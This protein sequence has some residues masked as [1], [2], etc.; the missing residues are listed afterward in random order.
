MFEHYRKQKPS[1]LGRIVNFDE[2]L[3]TRILK[4]VYLA[5]AALIALGAVA[6][7]GLTSLL[8]LFTALSND[9]AEGAL[10]SL[11]FLGLSIGGG[12][13]GLLLWR[14]FCE[15]VIVVFKINENLQAV[16]DLGSAPHAKGTDGGTSGF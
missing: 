2:F 4:V 5:G 12:L 13:I 11:F 10:A 16:K 6:M 3:T 15:I 7:G 1:I 14:V 9:S 8:G